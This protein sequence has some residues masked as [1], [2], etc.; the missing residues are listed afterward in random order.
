MENL[1]DALTTVINITEKTDDA[2]KDGKISISEGVGL[3]FA[4]IGLI[5]VVKN[6]SS[7]IEDYNQLDD[8]QRAELVAWF[9]DEF[10]LENDN[11]EG[12]V[13]M[14]FAALLNLGQ[15]FDELKK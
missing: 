12:I 13:E 3:A 4:A 7:I 14:V 8:E 15:V 6:I 11:I 1:K 5:K 10:D 2:L 9:T